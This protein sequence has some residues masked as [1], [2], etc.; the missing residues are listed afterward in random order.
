MVIDGLNWFGCSAD[1]QW[2]GIVNL[3]AAMSTVV[4]NGDGL[5]EMVVRE[6]AEK[7]SLGQGTGL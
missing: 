1:L 6:F 5:L 2:V 4:V 3:V 7:G